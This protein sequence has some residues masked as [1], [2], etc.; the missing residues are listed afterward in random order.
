MKKRILT[1]LIFIVFTI[2]IIPN[3]AF[4][5]TKVNAT[6]P[7]FKVTLNGTELD[8]T[9]RQYP[10]ITYKGITYFPM[11]YYDC[12]YLGLETTWDAVKGLG[13]NKLQVSAPY[14]SYTQKVK[15]SNTQTA[16]IPKFNI[17]LNNKTIDN[18]K[19]EYPLL[20][21][22]DVTY[23]PMTWKFCVDEFGWKY[24]FDVKNGLVIKSSNPVVEKIKLVNSSG[25]FIATDKYYV[26]Q[27]TDGLIYRAPIDNT[28]KFSLADEKIEKEELYPQ[29]YK[30]NG[31]FMMANRVGTASIG[32]VM[33]YTINDDGTLSEPEYVRD[34]LVRY[35]NLMVTITYGSVGPIFYTLNVYDITNG[36]EFIRSYPD[37]KGYGAIYFERDITIIE[38]YIYYSASYGK[39]DHD[40][41]QYVYMK[42]G[43]FKSNIDTG[44]EIQLI[45]KYVQNFQINGQDIYYMQNDQ[46]YKTDIEN[47]TTPIILANGN[48]IS[49][50]SVIDGNIFYV[51]KNSELLYFNTDKKSLVESK[52]VSDLSIIDSYVVSEFRKDNY[53]PKGFA[54]YDNKGS[55]VFKSEDDVEFKSL[56]NDTAYFTNTVNND[57]YS[58]KLK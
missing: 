1:L 41:N 13:I 3:V 8:N 25:N 31:E 57:T 29:F 32:G 45:D 47:T 4:A 26:Y 18:S 10:L 36:K 30:S 2:I 51:E 43:L 53:N 52:K 38:R 7:K 14:N 40:K 28:S 9:Y 11:T 19:E 50:F 44:E 20:I 21:F 33:Y 5:D 24:N 42:K 23:F 12:R 58:V 56:N 55:L 46:L 37:N 22:R 15:N 27:G 49:S 54:I 6:L 16:S 17:S 39:Y 35:D 48:Q 34:T